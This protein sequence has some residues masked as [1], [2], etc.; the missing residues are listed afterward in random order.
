M[1]YFKHQL[2]VEVR[3]DKLTMWWYV[4]CFPGLQAKVDDLISKIDNPGENTK[5]R[6]S[7]TTQINQLFSLIIFVF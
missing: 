2:V 3:N 6:E 5:L 4:H 1:W 7:V